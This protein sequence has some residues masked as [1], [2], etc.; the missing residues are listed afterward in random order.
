MLDSQQREC[1]DLCSEPVGKK[2]VDVGG[3]YV[4]LDCAKEIVGQVRAGSQQELEE[5]FG[6]TV[7]AAY[8][9]VVERVRRRFQVCSMN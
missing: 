2:H 6:P 1:C 9:A 8:A 7:Q 4:C 5:F 3:R